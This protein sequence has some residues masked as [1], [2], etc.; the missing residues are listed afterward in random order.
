LPENLPHFTFKAQ[1]FWEQPAETVNEIMTLGIKTAD[2]LEEITS[3]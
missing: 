1:N 2:V 3:K